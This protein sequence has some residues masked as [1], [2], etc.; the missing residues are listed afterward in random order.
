MKR[1][2]WSYSVAARDTY[3]TYKYCGYSDDFIIDTVNKFY[4]VPLI[5]QRIMKR[6][7]RKRLTNKK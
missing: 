1:F 3:N 6:I 7:Y 2:R 4:G 5:K